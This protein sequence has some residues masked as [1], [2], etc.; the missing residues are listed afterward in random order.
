MI[1]N[2]RLREAVGSFGSGAPVFRVAFNS[3][4]PTKR[5]HK[6]H[7]ERKRNSEKRIGVRKEPSGGLEGEF[8]VFSRL[9]FPPL[10]S[11]RLVFRELPL[12]Y[13]RK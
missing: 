11:P 10:R 7:E 3:L 13:V 6:K 12:P 8:F 5:Y 9:N 2:A 1:S 4:G